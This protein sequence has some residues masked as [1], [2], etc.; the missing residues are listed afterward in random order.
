MHCQQRAISQ[1]TWQQAL[2]SFVALDV[3]ARTHGSSR[4]N[5]SSSSNRESYGS[6]PQFFAALERNFCQRRPMLA[7]HFC[8]IRGDK[9]RLTAQIAGLRQILIG[10]DDEKHVGF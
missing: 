2:M 7:Q 4:S 5:R 6:Q 1:L 8:S 10:M 9:H 3:L